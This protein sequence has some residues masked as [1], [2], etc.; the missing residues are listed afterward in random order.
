[1]ATGYD[2]CIAALGSG[3]CQTLAIEGAS[4][5]Q[6]A[7]VASGAIDPVQLLEELTGNI[8]ESSSI[9][10]ANAQPQS[11]FLGSAASTIAPVTN[12]ITSPTTWVWVGIIILL[13]LVILLKV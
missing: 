5:S 9:V 11:S 2:A 7:L 4:D 8:S 3:T 6:L 12:F 1:M 13:V 10:P